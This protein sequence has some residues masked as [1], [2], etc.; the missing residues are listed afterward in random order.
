[1]EDVTIYHPNDLIY[2]QEKLSKY[3]H[4]GYHPVTLGDT[5]DDG[6]YK[7]LHKLG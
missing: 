6:R 7:A 1:M 3:R 2:T 5:F 4:G